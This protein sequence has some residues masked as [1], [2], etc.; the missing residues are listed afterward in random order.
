MS[1]LSGMLI[2]QTIHFKYF[3]LVDLVYHLLDITEQ[4]SPWSALCYSCTSSDF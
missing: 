3:S 2:S 4:K 1:S